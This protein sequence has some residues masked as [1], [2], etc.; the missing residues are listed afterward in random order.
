MADTFRERIY[1]VVRQIPYGRVAT[2]GDVSLLA[3]K[4]NGAREVGWALSALDN[5]EVTPWWRVVNAQ[6]RISPRSSGEKGAWDQAE[7]LRE[8]GVSITADFRLDLKRY[9]WDG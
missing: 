7:R 4:P 8:E 3:G 1:A 2:Y 9:R 6:G 5:P